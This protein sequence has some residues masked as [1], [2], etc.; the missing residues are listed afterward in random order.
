MLM[1]GMMI[2]LLTCLQKVEYQTLLKPLNPE[3]RELTDHTTLFMSIT[4]IRGAA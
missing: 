4:Q 3:N 1:G 2:A